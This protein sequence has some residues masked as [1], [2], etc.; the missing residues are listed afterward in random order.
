MITKASQIVLNTQDSVA[1]LGVIAMD[2]AAELGEKINKYLVQWAQESGINVDSYLIETQCPRF[3]SGDGKGLI[4]KSIRGD[5]IY[6]IVD[7]GNYAKPAKTWVCVGL[8][9]KITHWKPLP[10]PPEEENY[11]TE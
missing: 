4:K 2:G 3:S 11:G 10:Q 1:P 7:V 6:I 9:V 5:D 8:P